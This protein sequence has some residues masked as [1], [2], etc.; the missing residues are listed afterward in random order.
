MVTV[1]Q[2]LRT[3]M[4]MGFILG[5]RGMEDKS[6]SIPRLLQDI[7]IHAQMN[8][9][10]GYSLRLGGGCPP[11]GD[12]AHAKVVQRPCALVCVAEFGVAQLIDRSAID[13]RTHGV[14]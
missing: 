2:V 4:L 6:N 11:T 7:S 10:C 5:W 12:D 14:V 13:L 1:L 9:I 3:H 8:L